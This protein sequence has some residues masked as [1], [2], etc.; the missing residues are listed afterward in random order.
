M[1]MDPNFTTSRFQSKSSA[2][3][4]N[5]IRS[6]LIPFLNRHQFHSCK[7]LRPEDLDRRVNILNKWWTGLLEMLN[8]K[9]NQSISGTD[10]PVYLEAV[11]GI[12][13]RPEWRI[14]FPM[15]HPSESLPRSLQHTPTSLSD[16]SDRSS[17]SDFLLE[18]IHHN[19]RNIFIQNLLAQMAF[20]VERMSMRHAPASLVAFCGKACAYAFFF[21]P[22][23]ADALVR[24]WGTP[25]SSYKRVFAESSV[26]DRSSTA[27]RAFA[28]DLAMSFPVAL[29]SL[30]FHSHIPLVR[31]LRQKPDIPVNAS[32]IPWHS[33]WVSRWCGR[34]T[35]LFFVFVKFVHILYADSMPRDMD[36]KK[37]VLA[38][39]LLPIHA[40]LLIVLEKTLH[41]QPGP[42]G[43]TADNSHST[44]ATTFDDFIEGADAAVSALPL[45]AANSLRS[46]AENRL[47]ILLRDFLSESSVEPNRARLL[48]AESFCGIIKAAMQRTSLYDHNTCFLICDF[49]EEVIP[50]ITKYSQSVEMVLFD[51]SFW[52]GVCKKMMESH[53]SVT[54]V[55]VFSF[56]Y[57]MW[58]TWV[59]SEQRKEDLC[60]N[61]LLH[62][63][64]FYQY[65]NHWSS[66]V[67]SYFHRLLCWRVARL[68]DEPT[69]LNT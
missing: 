50:I 19:I 47:I 8:G 33:P 3:K 36:K 66:M 62:E 7:N 1:P 5:V 15:S 16:S 13:T 2:L 40:Q 10:R 18:S 67:R 17:G 68:N 54:E 26:L 30:S 38:P 34:D 32:Q 53:N 63:S 58:N 23:V 11:V 35:D 60:L 55:R 69:P 14:A 22:G 46:M 52:L 43:G 61:F 21:C 65:Y 42:Q 25:A 57:C 64:W 56:I 48:Y 51:W 37:R 45:G 28:Q 59:A 44:A 49:M 41:K 9:H 31:Y 4:A 12:M 6:S 20:V 29:Q 24:L 27:S 39:G